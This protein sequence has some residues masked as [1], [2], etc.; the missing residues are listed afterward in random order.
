MTRVGHHLAKLYAF[1]LLQIFNLLLGE[2]Q[3]SNMTCPRYKL[4]LQTGNPAS[5]ISIHQRK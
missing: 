3:A 4:V 2:K 1:A 5:S